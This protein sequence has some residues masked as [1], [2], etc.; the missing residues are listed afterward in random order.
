VKVVK[1]ELIKNGNR[2]LLEK[3]IGISEGRA[4]INVISIDQY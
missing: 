2:K 1:E 3:I 4:V